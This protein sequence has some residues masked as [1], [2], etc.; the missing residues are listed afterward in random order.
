MHWLLRALHEPE[1]QLRLRVSIPPADVLHRF[2]SRMAVVRSAVWSPAWGREESFVGELDSSS[3]RMRARHGYTNGFTRLLEGRIE[4]AGNG[5]GI[6]LRFRSLWWVELIMRAL[7]VFLLAMASLLALEAQRHAAGAPTDSRV[8]GLALLGPAL[9][10]LFLLGV[11]GLGRRLGA[12]DELRMRDA[13]ERW[14][15]DVRSA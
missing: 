8:L 1:S 15:S 3:I 6:N 5:T 11:E 10:L 14:F 9:M 13:I 7:W 4:V 2:S 12:R